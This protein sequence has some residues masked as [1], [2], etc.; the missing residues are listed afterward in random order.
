MVGWKLY[1][2]GYIN[3]IRVGEGVTESVNIG[4][5]AKPNYQTE[6][7]ASSRLLERRQR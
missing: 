2:S 3:Q 4:T 6:P 1:D 7:V 5:A